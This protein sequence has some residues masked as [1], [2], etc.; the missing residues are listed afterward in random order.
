MYRW[1]LDL[2]GW[3]RSERLDDNQL[4]PANHERSFRTALVLAVVCVLNMFDLA[5][6]QTQMA[7]GNFAEL[8]V[9]AQ[10]ALEFGPLGA[11]VYKLA[12]FGIGVVILFRL[13]RHWESEAG[14]WILLSCYA[15]LMI[16]WTVY[17]DTVELCICD[18]AVDA[19]LVPF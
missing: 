12:L 1:H 14:A 19:P 17:L 11:A 3:K 9:L 16:W 6:T 18:P 7:R 4:T 5:F 13:R 10:H 2:V 15:V 8:N